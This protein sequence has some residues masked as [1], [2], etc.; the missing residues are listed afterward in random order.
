MNRGFRE[1]ENELPY[2][3]FEKR[4]DF[5]SQSKGSSYGEDM[6]L[7]SVL[8]SLYISPSK[9]NILKGKLVEFLN[10]KD[11][12]GL[13]VED[14]FDGCDFI[15]TQKNE[16]IESIHRFEYVPQMELK[17]VFS[18][19]YSTHNHDRLL[20]DSRFRKLVEKTGFEF[21]GCRGGYVA[22]YSMKD[23]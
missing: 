3:L 18:D 6:N 17:R 12:T 22:N 1:D 13:R 16:Y 11:C 10:A 20:A 8:A 14:G 9:R 5:T 19:C 2:L 15:F 4:D 23:D 21:M 7:D